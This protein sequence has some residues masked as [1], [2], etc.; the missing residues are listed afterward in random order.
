M[1]WIEKIKNFPQLIQNEPRYGYLVVAAI[2]LIW[3]IG[4]IF[5][6][7]WTY[8]RPGSTGGNA[9][10]NLLGPRTFRFWLG[11]FITI[12]IATAIYLFVVTGKP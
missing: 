6:W 4:V 9:L 3:L 10:M 12:L 5:G 2:L 7:R 11:I 8:S 1:D